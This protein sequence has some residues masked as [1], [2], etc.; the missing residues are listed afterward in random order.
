MLL[1]C[2]NGE[3]RASVCHTM[4]SVLLLNFSG[5]NRSV[6]DVPN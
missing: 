6:D 5:N 4:K 1:D 3:A 2:E